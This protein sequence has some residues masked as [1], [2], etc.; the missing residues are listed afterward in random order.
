MHQDLSHKA[1]GGGPLNEPILL[2]R[3]V[4]FRIEVFFMSCRSLS[5]FCRANVLN[6]SGNSDLVYILNYKHEICNS[7]SFS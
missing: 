6:V 1:E 5:L 7:L 2:G 3:H 4:R